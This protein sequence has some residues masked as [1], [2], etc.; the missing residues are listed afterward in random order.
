MKRLLLLTILLL[1]ACTPVIYQ[2]NATKMVLTDT[3]GNRVV[4]NATTVCGY[5]PDDVVKEC[6]EL[7]DITVVFT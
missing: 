2:N 6:A 3:D 5:T 4:Y 7:T 1:A